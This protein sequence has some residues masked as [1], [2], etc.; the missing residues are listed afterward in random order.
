MILGAPGRQGG[1]CGE[2]RMFLDS[3]APL[4]IE[5]KGS[6]Y[7]A[8][9][10]TLLTPCKTARVV[11]CCSSSVCGLLRSALILMR[12]NVMTVSSSSDLWT[13]GQGGERFHERWGSRPRLWRPRGHSAGLPLLLP[14][15]R[16]GGFPAAPPF[17]TMLLFNMAVFPVP[18]AFCTAHAVRHFAR[19][20][21]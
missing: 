12:Q 2:M 14:P 20:F 10:V 17:F 9:K 16:H 8:L 15:A 5:R 21:V 4:Q 18:N 13:E 1:M 7:G 19:S 3:L 6:S 11:C